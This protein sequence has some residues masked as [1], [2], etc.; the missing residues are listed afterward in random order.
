MV[1]GIAKP[2]SATKRHEWKADKKQT[3]KIYI[4]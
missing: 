1:D 4:Y 2:K 3:E